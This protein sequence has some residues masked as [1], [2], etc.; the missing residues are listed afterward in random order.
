MKLHIWLLG[1]AFAL[2]GCVAEPPPPPVTTTTVT[3]EVTTTTGTPTDE[4]LVTQA[5]PAV[6]VE[7]QTVAPGSNYVWQRGYWRWTGTRYVWVGGTW[8][9]RPSVRAV[10]V[11]GHWVRR[12]RGWVWVAGHW[13]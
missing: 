6:R 5:P 10:W 2:I 7:T 13:Q 8:I 11:E 4:V 9:A 1:V 12:P 3:R